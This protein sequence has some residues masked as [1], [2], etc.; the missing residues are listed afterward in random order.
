MANLRR[1]WFKFARLPYPSAV[2]RGC[3]VTAYGYDDAIEILKR[4]VFLGRSFPHIL[5]VQED[6]DLSQ[7]DQ[8]HVIPNMGPPHIRGIWFPQ[9]Y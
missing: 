1:Y 5:R 7:I 4:T 3:G 6:I 8:T 2:N 9:G